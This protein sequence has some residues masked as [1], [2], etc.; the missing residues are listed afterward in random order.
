M[1]LDMYQATVSPCVRALTNLTAILDKAQAYTTHLKIDQGVLLNARLFPDMLPLTMQIVIAGDT[2][3]GGAA[4]LAGVAVPTF[5]SGKAT[6]AELIGGINGSIA[7]IETLQP[8]QFDG[9]EDRTVTWSTRSSTKQMQG[10]PYLFN[11]ILPNVFFHVTTAYDI[12]R[13][14]GLNIGKKDYL[15]NA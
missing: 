4:R 1:A 2:A 15:G 10:M 9:A 7:F 12:L 13:H 6:F 8:E 5:E 14:S 3:R 11:H